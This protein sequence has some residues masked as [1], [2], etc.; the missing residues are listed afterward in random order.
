MLNLL[1]IEYC[2]TDFRLIQGHLRSNGLIARCC[3]VA[4]AAD[5]GRALGAGRWDLVLTNPDHA[6][7]DVR[8]VVALSKTRQ[9]AI[10]V[11]VIA[12]ELQEDSI[13]KM[14]DWGVAE[15]ILRNHLDR[16]V[17]AIERSVST[18]RRAGSLRDPQGLPEIEEEAHSRILNAIGEGI[19]DWRLAEGCIRHNARWCR[20][21]GLEEGC[22]AHSPDEFLARVHSAD[23]QA[24]WQRIQDCLGGKGP[25]RSEHRLL[26]ADGSCVWVIERGDV[27]ERDAAG[28]ALRMVGSAFDISPRKRAERDLADEIAQ[29]NILFEQSRDGI[30]IL[31][32][33]GKVFD[34]NRRFASML[35]RTPEEV[36]ET[37]VWDWDAEFDQAALRDALRR[38]DESGDYFETRHRR[39]DGSVYDVEIT[40]S[41][42]VWGGRK[43]VYCICRDITQRKAAAAALRAREQTL[44]AVVRAAPVG[45]ALVVDRIIIEANAYLRQLLGYTE[46]EFRALPTRRLY[47]SDAE[48]ERIGDAMHAQIAA[49]GSATMAT[50]WHSKGGD[51]IVALLSSASLDAAKPG[52]GVVLTVLDITARERAEAALRQSE[53]HL[54]TLVETIPDLV[55]LKDPQG[56]YLTC[57][58]M[59]ERL[60]GAK[61]AGI[62]GKTDFDFVPRAVAE[63]FRQHDLK[64]IS[65][66]RSTINEEWLTFA[67]D[68]YRALMQTI[69]TPMRD[70][71]GRVVGVLG[72]AREITAARQAE[73]TLRQK[74]RYQRALL[75]NFPF[76]VWLKDT[77]SRFLAVN[78]TLARMFGAP[79]A[80]AL[81]GKT[82]LDLAPPEMAEGYRADDR[83]VMET[84]QMRMFEEE[85]LDSGVPKW[86]ETF[87]APVLD[88]N[89]E[90]L[91]TV[92][93]ARD[94]T[95]R[96]RM[97]RALRESE[98]RA[99]LILATAPEAMLVIDG[100]GRVIIANARA[101][102]VFGYPAGKM[103]GLA[104]ESLIPEK[105][106]A[107]HVR[108]RD[109]FGQGPAP[110]PMAHRQSLSAVRQDGSEFPV[111]VGLGPLRVGD[112]ALT[113]VSVLDISARK[114]AEADLRE[115]QRILHQAQAIAR[116]GSWSIDLATRKFNPSDEA[117]RLVGWTAEP[118]SLDD[119]L[120]VVHHEDRDFVRT[121]WFEALSTGHYECGHRVIV[122]GKARWVMAKGEIAFDG[123]GRPVTAVG[124]TQDTTEVREAQIALQAHKEHLEELV[125]QRTAELDQQARYLRALIDN[126]PH[127]VWLKDTAG[128]YL[129]SNRTNAKACGVPMEQMTGTTDFD[130]WP[131]ELA[132]RYRAAD[133]EVIRSG[134]QKIAEE[135]YADV[136]KGTIVAEACRTPVFAED[137]RIIATAGFARDVSA[138]KA[139]EAARE[140]AL[141]EARRLAQVRSDFLANMSHEIRTPLNAVLGLAQVGERE[142]AGRKSGHTFQR[143][144]DSGQLLLGIVNDIL[145][146]SKIEAG[147]LLLDKSPFNLGEVIDRAIDVTAE[148]AFAKGIRLVVRE[149][150]DL[151]TTCIGDALRLSQILVNLLSNA[152]KFTER[153]SVTLTAAR[154]GDV[155]AL[156][157][158]DTGIGMNSEQCARLFQPF[159]QADSST[160]RR[161]GGTGLGLAIS[162]RLAELMGGGITLESRAGVG[163]VFAVRLALQG[164]TDG[165]A[166][167][168]RHVVLAGL[169]EA[170]AKPLADA[171]ANLGATVVLASPEARIDQ[172]C[173]VL[174]V[175][176]GSFADGQPMPIVEAALRQGL[177]FAVVQTPGVSLALPSFLDGLEIPIHRP[178][179]ARHILSAANRTA[180]V[181]AQIPQR[182]RL[183]E[184]RILAA[185]DNEINRLVLGEMLGG[186]GAHLCCVEDGQLAVERIRNDGSSA[187]DVVLMDV[188]MPV[189]NGYEASRRLIELAPRLPIVGLTAHAMAEERDRCIAA[190]MAAHVAKPVDLNELVEVILRLVR[191]Q[192]QQQAS[193]KQPS[194]QTQPA[195]P[196]LPNWDA[197]EARFGGKSEFVTRLA[198]S[199]LRSHGDTP[200]KLRQAARRGDR[201]E[202]AFLS[203]SIKGIAGNLM[204]QTTED[205]AQRVNASANGQLPDAPSLAEDLADRLDFILRAMRQR[206]GTSIDP[207][208]VGLTK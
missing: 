160:T 115:S 10:P 88:E 84:R 7:L 25:Y 26:R 35:G 157:V 62:V 4:H 86:F 23:R 89:G 8:S 109:T 190:G 78:E 69:K 111:E 79:G 52:S 203:H 153:G 110:R 31:D 24:V 91:G 29:R 85:I 206:T 162:Q 15:V 72:V 161:F 137:G 191:G 175:D 57:N 17:P 55:W 42:T 174:V 100:E 197:L 47:A 165:P 133:Q 2:E 61:E 149:A 150:P 124:V 36:R 48:Y 108:H 156:Q 126:V 176:A 159:E 125:A 139:T 6:E 130:L 87:K 144:R 82:D 50:V 102:S 63:V 158:V 38:I 51:E 207:A 104:V 204:L 119:F 21:L 101:D 189:M 180:D 132:G 166:A 177:R 136:S 188:Q 27:I 18:A 95:E 106:R 13:T 138:Y 128:R 5:V 184:V 134:R 45:I 74:E 59:F 75:D 54:R 146:F 9:P 39:K 90:L 30:V 142:S 94:V 56:V 163:S 14:N 194:I 145:D 98:A 93:F 200:D 172:P 68:G 60:F 40:N 195:A 179:R 65:A 11:I 164:A 152:V 127:P 19:W 120:E 171:L 155:L 33:E 182:L 83:W 122:S 187:F 117:A 53:T 67:D 77:E 73:E 169:R 198:K 123:D 34:V 113:I 183:K 22:P 196:D 58:P 140:A 12:E 20:L 201:K 80:D 70:A 170:E 37:H 92:G 199:M 96:R 129:V 66:G 205:L 76:A 46:D 99:N 192:T 178:L 173:D 147:K 143:I 141:R 167:A 151:P 43:F 181:P 81:V 16:L 97:E 154:E 107:S 116:V 32:D 114:Q 185:D 168:K 103:L 1:I 112:Q 44:S 202:L 121:A 64:A 186:E 3:H 49:T 71:Q 131:E 148:K 208:E 105:F 28:R 193:G 41:A 118:H 135:P